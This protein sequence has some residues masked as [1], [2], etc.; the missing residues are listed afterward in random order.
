M[1]LLHGPQSRARTQGE[2]AANYAN[3][4]YDALFEKMKDMPS[5]PERQRLIDRM[6]DIARRDAPWIWGIHP[7]EYSLS[8]SWLANDK[9]N[10]MARNN[11][12]YLKVD[13]RKRA[14]LRREWNRPVLW[15]LGIILA[16]LIAGAVPAIVSVRRRERL[17]ARPT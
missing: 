17:A 4:G 7:K 12:K 8:H 5:S 15:P 13:A 11:I 10:N 1:F 16:I 3:P 14:A 9:P 2:N 6:V